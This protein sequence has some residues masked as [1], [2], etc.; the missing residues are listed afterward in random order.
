MR[1]KLGHVPRALWFKPYLLAPHNK[2][3]VDY[4]LSLWRMVQL[5]VTSS[6]FNVSGF[7]LLVLRFDFLVWAF[8]FWLSGFGFCVLDFGTWGFGFW[9]LMCWVIGIVFWVFDLWLCVLGCWAFMFWVSDF[10]VELLG[11]PF[12]GSGFWVLILCVC[13]CF[14]V[15][16]F[17]F[18]ILVSCSQFWI[19]AFGCWM[20]CFM[21]F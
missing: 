1:H 21:V 7:E 12:L 10:I 5:R 4:K 3:N 15:C 14:G 8:V 13:F 2:T 9:V 6:G 18:V 17:G 11:F 19:F 20:F 16:V